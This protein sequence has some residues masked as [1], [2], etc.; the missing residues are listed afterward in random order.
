METT[1][2]ASLEL[3]QD[4][5]VAW[6]SDRGHAPGSRGHSAGNG[7]IVRYDRVTNSF[8]W[9]SNTSCDGATANERVE[10][11]KGG[12]FITWQSCESQL[13]PGGCGSCDGN[14]EAFLFDEKGATITQLTI[15]ANGF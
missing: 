10:I 15:S 14:D 7:R 1:G 3:A 5:V 13:N 2:V 4:S 9:V 11:S 8:L 12:R 6:H